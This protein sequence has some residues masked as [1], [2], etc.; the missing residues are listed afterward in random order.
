MT[1]LATQISKIS[2]QFAIE[3]EFVRGKE[4]ESGLINTT[5]L[6][7]YE[8]EEGERSRYVLQRINEQVFPEPH[9]VMRTFPR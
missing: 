5:Y 2:S 3:G 7:E 4:I 9:T 6:A 8:N 1:D